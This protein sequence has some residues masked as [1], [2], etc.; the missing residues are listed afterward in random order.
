MN[1]TNVLKNRPNNEVFIWLCNI[2][3]ER[4]WHPQD[5]MLK[6]KP[7]LRLINRI[8]EI[9]LLLCKR[10]D[11]IILRDIPDD[12]YL[13]TAKK[14]GFGT[15]N[16]LSP[17]KKGEELSISELILKDE[18]LLEKLK[19]IN[20]DNVYF[21]PYAVTSLEEQIADLCG[22]SLI[23][24]NSAICKKL[25]DKI[26]NR[27][28]ATILK[29]PTTEGY[30]CESLEDILL[31]YQTLVKSN[32]DIPLKVVIKN[33]HN[34]SGQG[35]YIAENERQLK[36]VL[37]LLGRTVGA[38][39]WLIEKWYDKK[40]DINYQIFVSSDGSVNMFSIKQQFV[41]DTVFTGSLIPARLNERLLAE[42]KAYSEKIG[43]YLFAIGYTGIAGIDA[44]IVKD[45][46]IPIIEI[47][48]RFTLSTY[49]SFLNEK[50]CT[51]NIL[52]QYFDLATKAPLAY[53]D[54]LN[55]IGEEMGEQE[56]ILIFAPSLLPDC[57][58][59]RGERYIGR[60]FVLF[61]GDDN[62]SVMQSVIR[63]KECVIS[64]ING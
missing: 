31:H 20:T 50:F 36:S 51:E 15:P 44:I 54:V 41:N 25:N 62:D 49:L 37:S 17:K 24:A 26:F 4:F 45:K 59:K 14:L 30:V 39:N 16:I 58:S 55:I 56:N 61:Y 60:L 34:A 12:I 11:Y 2:G 8:E 13:R 35:M 64:K 23:G 3:A 42:I 43:E 33:P 53:R 5:S 28:I 10:Q 18:R 52:F 9:N 46:I 22:F 7:D 19:E 57:N 27:Q 21:F 48:A 63:F 6:S 47:N 29:L 38:G 40:I 32:G 1:F